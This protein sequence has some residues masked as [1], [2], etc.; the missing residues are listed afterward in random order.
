VSESCR[1]WTGPNAY[2]RALT[3]QSEQL[4]KAWY[5]A[6]EIDR[7]EYRHAMTNMFLSCCQS[8]LTTSHSNVPPELTA[9]VRTSPG[10]GMAVSS[11][12]FAESNVTICDG[13]RV[14]RPLAAD[15]KGRNSEA[16]FDCLRHLM[17]RKRDGTPT[18]LMH[19]RTN[20]GFAR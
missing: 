12:S 7:L 4:I 8:L 16:Y 3:D 19:D 15:A 17:V 2:S 6:G 11:D 14:L 13:L 1:L 5:S 9:I 18:A 20:R 10:L